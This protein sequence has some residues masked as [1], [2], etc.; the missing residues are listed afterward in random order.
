MEGLEK[1]SRRALLVNGS[2]DQC[3]CFG[4]GLLLPDD[5]GCWVIFTRVGSSF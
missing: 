2:G 1:V 3:R 5:H 4:C